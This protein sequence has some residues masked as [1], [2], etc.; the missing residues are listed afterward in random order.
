MLQ[1]TLLKLFSGD[2]CFCYRSFQTVDNLKAAKIFLNFLF[3][4][5]QFLTDISTYNV[6]PISEPVLTV[7]SQRTSS[8]KWHGFQRWD[9]LNLGHFF[10]NKTKL[11]TH[12]IRALADELDWLSY[13]CPRGSGSG[14]L[15]L[16]CDCIPYV[17]RVLSLIEIHSRNFTVLSQRL[18]NMLIKVKRSNL[19]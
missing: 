9:F 15:L 2:A 16:I 19:N 17:S 12:A 10:V 13:T 7:S 1:Y 11:F 6:L 5:Q 4:S 18:L 8:V 14:G 3:N